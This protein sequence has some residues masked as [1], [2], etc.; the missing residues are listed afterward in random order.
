MIQMMIRHQ[1]VGSDALNP[2]LARELTG[3]LLVQLAD[4]LFRD[5]PPGCHSWTD[6]RAE[7]P[8]GSPHR[9]S[10]LWLQFV[11]FVPIVPG[12]RLQRRVAVGLSGVA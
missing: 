9:M 11:L 4:L 1:S 10:N 6:S 5:L 2:L 12:G 3:H 8:E 7:T